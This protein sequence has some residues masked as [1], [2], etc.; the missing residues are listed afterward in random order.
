MSE[1]KSSAPA[2]TLAALAMLTA[3]SVSAAPPPATPAGDIPANF[4]RPEAQN[5]YIKRVEM[6]PMRDGVKLYTVIVIP[7]SA[8][9]API[10]LTRTPYNAKKRAERNDSPSMLSLLP[11][12]DENRTWLRLRC[13]DWAAAIDGH[14]RALEETRDA[15]AVGAAGNPGDRRSTPARSRSARCGCR[16]R[17]AA[18]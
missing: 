16:S 7:K 9:H 3:S 11:L 18:Q 2:V 6:I 12:S 17:T 13:E 10:I 14:L 15:A 5:D 1:C 4:L 8:K